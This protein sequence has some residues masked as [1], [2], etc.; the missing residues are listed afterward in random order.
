MNQS[1]L[2]QRYQ[3]LLLSETEKISQKEAGKILRLSERQIRRLLRKLRDNNFK[4][5]SL[6]FKSH[7]AWN[8]TDKEIE[9]KILKLNEDYPLAL[10]SHLSWLAWDLY[11]L[12]I[13]DRTVKIYP[14]QPTCLSLFAPVIKKDLILILL[15]IILVIIKEK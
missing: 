13:K 1:I 10:N 6:E 2:Q 7:P 4:I 12:E 11:E 5:E 8:R 15:I 14:N 9:E 3:V